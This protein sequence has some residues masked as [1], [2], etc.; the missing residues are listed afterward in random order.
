MA[1]PKTKV[2]GLPDSGFFVDYASNRT[3]RHDYAR[4]IKAL[5]DTVNQITP[6]PNSKCA[7]DNKENPHNCMM[8]EHLV[9]YI[10][11]PIFISESTYDFYQMQAI[12][13]IPCMQ[14]PYWPADINNCTG[15]DDQLEEMAKFA[16]YTRDLLE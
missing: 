15:K 11:T 8:A 3:G 5:V 2:F 10:E 1:N 7:Q 13:Q 12:L 9:K 16:N 4:K 14:F 6:L